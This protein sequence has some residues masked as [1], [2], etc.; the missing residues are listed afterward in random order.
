MSLPSN[1]QH[2]SKKCLSR[3][4]QIIFLSFFAL[5]LAICLYRTSV[6]S[7]KED[8]IVVNLGDSIAFNPSATDPDGDI[9]AFSYSGW[10]DSPYYITRCGDVGTHTVTVT[11]SDG[12]LTDSREVTVQVNYL[13]QV[14]LTWDPN[15]EEDLAGYKL[16]YGTSSGN[17]NTVVNAG[18]QSYYTLSNL[19]SGQTYYISVTSYDLSGNDST[20][21]S[22]IIYTVPVF[23]DTDEDGAPDTEDAFPDDPGRVE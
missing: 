17:Y 21:S 18:N 3:Y 15:T 11:V 8:F 7:A 13:S 22:E 14:T 12:S 4:S 16:H 23:N 20:N 5:T 6:C 1:S 2:L 19:V 9:L 10:M